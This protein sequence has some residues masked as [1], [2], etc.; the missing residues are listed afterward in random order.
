MRS[1]A[2]LVPAALLAVLGCA[3]AVGVP[4]EPP[5]VNTYRSPKL[6]GMERRKVLVVPF[7]HADDAVARAVTEAFAL[8]LEKTLFFEVVSPYGPAAKDFEGLR[9]WMDGGL[10]IRSLTALR[11]RFKVDA[12]AVGQVTQYRAYDPP[13]LGMRAQVVSARSGIVLW[14]TEGCFDAREAGVR[15]LVRHFYSRCLAT[16]ERSHGWKIVLSSPRYYAQFVAHQLVSTLDPPR[17]LLVPS[18]PL[19]GSAPQCRSIVS[20]ILSPQP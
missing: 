19:L 15:T 6:D 2:V 17:S 16:P 1:P 4:P 5:A 3:P 14:G 18:D 13:V 10:E 12:V 11:R 8:E 20:T 7:R 9:V